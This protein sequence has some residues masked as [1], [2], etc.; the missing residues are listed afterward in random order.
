MKALKESPLLVVWLVLLT[1]GLVYSL[2]HVNVTVTV[3]APDD[4][5][6]SI[7]STSSTTLGGSK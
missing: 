4:S 6:V 1:I 2:F 5:K 7:K 3:Q